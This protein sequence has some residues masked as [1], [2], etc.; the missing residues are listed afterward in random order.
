MKKRMILLFGIILFILCLLFLEKVYADELN[1][2]IA[3]DINDYGT[4]VTL[5]THEN[6]SLELESFDSQVALPPS[7]YSIFYSN[8]TSGGTEYYLSVDTWNSTSNPRTLYLI[9]YI[10]EP[11]AGNI[12]FTWDALLANF[13]GNFSYYGDDAFYSSLIDSLNMSD[14]SY[15]S[16]AIYDNLTL[17]VSVTIDNLPLDV[18]PPDLTIESP[19]NAT[20]NTNTIEFNVSGTETLSSCNFTIDGTN[21]FGMTSFNTTYFNY[22]N[23][24]MADGQYYANFT[25]NDTAGNVNNTEFIVFAVDTA[26]APNV[27]LNTP[28]NASTTTSILDTILNWT[29]SDDNGDNMEVWVYGSNDSSIIGEGNSLL[30]HRIGLLDGEYNFN[31]TSLLTPYDGSSLVLLLHF[32]NLT[33]YGEN[34]AVVYDFANG[35]DNGS[36]VEGTWNET[37]KFAG[38]YE[39]DGTNDAKINVSDGGDSNLD[40]QNF[41]IA[42]WFMRRGDGS[43]GGFSG[44]S[45]SLTEVLTSKGLG[46]GD[47]TGVD[48]GWLIGVNDSRYM[49]ACFEDPAGVDKILTGSTTVIQNETWYHAVLTLN[50]F[51]ATFYLNGIVESSVTSNAYAANNNLTLSI[52]WGAEDITATPD[53]AW[54]GSIDEFAIW[55]RSL[56]ASEVAELYNL[57]AQKYYWRVNATDSVKYNQSD[58]YEF[59]IQSEA[60]ADNPPSITIEH[61]INTTYSTS[62][63]D[64]NITGNEDLSYCN[65]TL[66]GT[67]YLEMTQFNATLFNFTNDSMLA[68]QYT[69]SFVCNDTTGNI[70]ETENVT[71]SIDLTPPNI[72]FT[73]PTP[74]NG[75][76]TST[77]SVE[78]NITTTETDLSNFV[79]SWN[80]TNFTI[81][82]DSLRV[83]FNFENSS[84]LGECDDWWC[85]ISDL[86]SYGNIGILR[87]DSAN[88]AFGNSV[89]ESHLPEWVSDGK[90]GGAFYFDSNDSNTAGASILILHSD[91][92]NPDSNDFAMLFW[93]RCTDGTLDTDISRKGSTNTAPTNWYKMEVGGYGVSDLLSLQFNTDGADD[94]TLESST[95]FCDNN[96]HFAV[97]QRIGTSAELW[98][99]AINQTSFTAGQA[100]ATLAGSI[101]NTANLSIG[102]KDTQNDDFFNG[103]LDEYRIYINRS[104][105]QE[106][107]ELLYMYNLQE[108]DANKFAFYI[109]QT[110]NTTDVLDTGTYLYFASA[111]DSA[112]NINMT[113]ERT[114]TIGANTAPD[115]PAVSINS[116]DE[117][118]NDTMQNLTCYA[119]IIDADNNTMN[120]TVE[121]YNGTSVYLTLDYN[122]T[123]ENGTLFMAELASEN[124]TKHEN[125]SCG[126]HLYDGTDYSSWANSSALDIVNSIPA[127][128]LADPIDGSIT[129]NRTPEFNWTGSDKDGDTLSYEINLTCWEAGSIVSAGSKY[130]DTGTIGSATSYISAVGDYLVCLSDNGQNYN[131]TVRVSDGEEFSSW[132][133][134]E[135]NLSIQSSVTISLP[136]DGVDFGSMNPGTTNHTTSDAPP[137]FVLQND[138]NCE[139]NISVNASDLFSTSTN[140]TNDYLYQIRDT[141]ASFSCYAVE[142]TYLDWVP[143]Q[144]DSNISINRL[145]FTSGYQSGCNNASIDINITVPDKEP[146][147]ESEN[148]TSIVTFTASLAELKVS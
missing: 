60:P 41:T 143:M 112:G 39:F 133:A 144:S 1:L 57:T 97:G 26:Y 148:K 33:E 16:S 128:S 74:E 130:K 123:Y 88:D 45:N 28:E 77:A 19:A 40:L 66:D 38:A 70:N 132:N 4:D 29:I 10:S 54:N 109:N 2:R 121:W 85:N 99:D 139:V 90:Y 61:P 62:V 58:I 13:S 56:S 126:L 129:T 67:G 49:A 110:K 113:E 135:N 120:V 43:N 100:D 14:S 69:A 119:T 8:I 52:G 23:S 103:T 72:N 81:M 53:G 146:G 131:W 116:T 31:W 115:T 80:N 50:Y 138:G 71:F 64:F 79:Y 3:A 32:D 34:S 20:Y 101:S 137:P 91:S 141:T 122:N 127:V 24:S 102:G 86:S 83:W 114:I 51:T 89:I 15:Y 63:I 59:T 87:N 104:F 46:G 98:V 94:A 30:Y 107:I 105:S 36:I 5:K 12:S 11:Q 37:G 17:Y 93:F 136:V 111:Q 47:N 75:A 124:T 7:N 21:W 6:A 73:E 106:E 118:L 96:W 84:A 68:G 9:Y 76:S 92:L 44:C 22:T 142:G 65:F 108:Y 25:C 147:G 48:C 140:P 35:D 125:W 27:T 42:F 145:N 82:D 55:N 117:T 95:D 18:T 134:A 78:I